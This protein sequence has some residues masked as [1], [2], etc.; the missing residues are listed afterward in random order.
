MRKLTEK[1]LATARKL[2]L[3]DK[4]MRESLARLNKMARGERIPTVEEVEFERD[5]KAGRHVF[6]AEWTKGKEEAP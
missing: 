3:T 6:P 4:E 2:N 5:L 1:E